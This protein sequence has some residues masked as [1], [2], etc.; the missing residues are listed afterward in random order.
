MTPMTIITFEEPVVQVKKS[1]IRRLLSVFFLTPYEIF[2]LLISVSISLGTIDVMGRKAKEHSTPQ[3]EDMIQL[4]SDKSSMIEKYL[5]WD[6]RFKEEA[7]Q[8]STYGL[9]Q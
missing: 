7:Q 4:F 8:R 5:Q 9:T 6:K 2:V 1:W 3:P